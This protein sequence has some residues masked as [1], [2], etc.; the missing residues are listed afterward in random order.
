MELKNVRLVYRAKGSDGKWGDE[1]VSARWDIPENELEGAKADMRR[2]LTD[3]RE[4]YELLVEDADGNRELIQAG[5]MFDGAIAGMFVPLRDCLKN[6]RITN[7]TPESAK[8]NT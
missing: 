7:E 6:R 4:N 2:K 5:E 1:L 3:E 8:E